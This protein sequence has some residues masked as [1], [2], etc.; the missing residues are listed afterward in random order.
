MIA[1]DI[2][3]PEEWE[4]YLPSNAS[5]F[6]RMEVQRLAKMCEDLIRSS[7]SF[8]QKTVAAGPPPT[9]RNSGSADAVIHVHKGE[10]ITQTSD[11]DPARTEAEANVM[12]FTSEAETLLVRATSPT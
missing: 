2:A 12:G 4:A 3:A 8:A 1:K 5:E 10:A 9:V 7:K 11:L 6:A